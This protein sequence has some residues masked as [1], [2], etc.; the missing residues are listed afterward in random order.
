MAGRGPQP[1]DPSKRVRRNADPTAETLL[2]FEEAEQPN[3]PT[4]F[5]N[6]EVDGAMVRRKYQWP[7]ITRDWWA[8]WRDSPQAEHFGST[9]WSFLLD[10]ALLHAEVWGRG[11]MKHAP[12][13]R[14]RVAKFGATPE[15]R[16]RLRMQF[17]DADAADS[18]R[19]APAA[20]SARERRGQIQVLRPNEKASGE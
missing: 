19:A 10:T 20:A 14:L 4:F 11:E 12:E 3:L 5:L 13:L 17:A 16:A 7:K 6:V 9:D 1:K 2:R 8:M 18:K 15:D